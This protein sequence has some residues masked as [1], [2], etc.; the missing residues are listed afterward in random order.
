MWVVAAYPSA[1]V[2]D[3]FLNDGHILGH[4]LNTQVAAGH[5]DAVTYLT[6]TQHTLMLDGLCVWDLCALV[7]TLTISSIFSTADGFSTLAISL[8]SP[9][10]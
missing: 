5:H 2:N 6:H 4:H 10:T 7:V 1:S 3:L 9:S 8:T